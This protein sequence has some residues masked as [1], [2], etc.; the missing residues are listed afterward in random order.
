MDE[1]GERARLTAG[2]AP[3]L[4]GLSVEGAGTVA[5]I[6]EPCTIV[7]CQGPHTTG[8]ALP[9]LGPALFISLLQSGWRP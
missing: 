6:Q 4:H 5:A 2:A 8:D 9:A 1:K 7:G 3:V